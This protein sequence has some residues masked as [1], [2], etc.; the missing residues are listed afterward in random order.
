MIAPA[1]DHCSKDL[2]IGAFSPRRHPRH[3]GLNQQRVTGKLLGKS[4]A[5]R[6]FQ[7]MGRCAW[8]DVHPFEPARQVENIDPLNLGHSGRQRR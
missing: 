6:P 1:A 3:F 7:S 5:E 8:R 2:P 4:A